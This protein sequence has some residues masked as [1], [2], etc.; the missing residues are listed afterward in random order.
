MESARLSIDRGGRSR[1][2]HGLGKAEERRM[3]SAPGTA[4][5]MHHSWREMRLEGQLQVR[6]LQPADAQLN[7]ELCLLA[8]RHVPLRS[9]EQG[10]DAITWCQKD[11]FSE[12]NKCS[13]KRLKPCLG[14]RECQKE[15]RQMGTDRYLRRREVTD[16]LHWLIT[17]G[18]GWKCFWWVS[19]V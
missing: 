15:C 5:R 2:G 17:C 11:E 6:F 12:G 8:H 1:Q 4:G 7:L 13:V 14:T 18:K 19:E 3:V 16:G 9:F 10:G